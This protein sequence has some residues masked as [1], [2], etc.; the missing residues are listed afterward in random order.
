[1][2]VSLHILW[3]LSRTCRFAVLHSSYSSIL[4]WNEVHVRFTLS[5]WLWLTIFLLREVLTTLQ[6]TLTS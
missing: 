3:A 1:M 5:A 4:L 6:A 2:L